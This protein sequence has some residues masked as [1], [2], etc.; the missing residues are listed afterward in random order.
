M[1]DSERSP[2][3]EPF[4]PSTTAPSRTPDTPPAPPVSLAAGEPGEVAPISAAERIMSVDVLRGVLGILV[5]NIQSFSMIG[6]AYMNPTAYGDL[7]GANWWVWLLSHLLADQKFMTIFSMLFGA[8]IVVFTSR[9]E[10]RGRRPAGLH[11]R[12]MLWLIIFG[13]LHAH[14]LWY[15]D[16]LYSYGMCGLA[17]YL[18][19]RLRPRWLILIGITMLLIPFLLSLA[20]GWSVRYWPEQA[21]EENLVQW[22]PGPDAVS[23]ELAA[24]R[25]SWLEQMSIRF[26][27]LVWLQTFV[28]A[29]FIAWRAGGLMLLGMALFKLGVFSAARSKAFYAVLIA[30]AVLVGMPV[31]LDGVHRHFEEGWRYDYSWFYGSLFNYWASILV[32]LGWVGGVMLVC[33]APG[34]RPLTRPFAAA[35]RMAFTNY[36]L[37]TVICT[38]IFYGHGLGLYGYASRVEQMLIVVAVWI[39][40]L[41]LS[42][43]WLRYF[44]FGPMEWLWRSLSYWR[45]QPMRREAEP[46]PALSTA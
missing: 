16:I 34:L 5:M 44:R 12:R 9:A 1:H 13:L 31:I 7:T 3:E 21:V 30:V 27:M 23:E 11:Y 39:L 37:Q 28:F 41:V 45:L 42:P 4:A 36:L 33:Q 43:L 20:A 46:P 29:F 24:Y 26:P 38:T 40:Q 10:A 32:S 2:S 17:A 8:G 6:A 35:G 22:A 14:L 18:F 19:R 25:G 15:G